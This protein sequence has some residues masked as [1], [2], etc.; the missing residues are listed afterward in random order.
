M[1]G[2]GEMD[3]FFFFMLKPWRG[4]YPE[5]IQCTQCKF[6]FAQKISDPSMHYGPILHSIAGKNQADGRKYICNY[7]GA[8][9]I[10]IDKIKFFF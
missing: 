8:L 6:L 9:L 2:G 10:N 5:E 4:F 7:K 1:R 3:Y